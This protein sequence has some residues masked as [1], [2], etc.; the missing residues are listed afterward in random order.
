[1]RVRTVPMLFC[2]AC[3]LCAGAFADELIPEHG[4]YSE[5]YQSDW[6]KLPT[7]RELARHDPGQIEFVDVAG[8]E[9]RRS[10]IDEQEEIRIS[11]ERLRVTW[12]DPECNKY[13]HTLY[14][15]RNCERVIIEDMAVIQNHDD[16][17]AASTFF[18]ESCGRVEI[19]NCYLAGTCEKPFIRLDGCEEYFID[20]VEIAGIDFGDGY[21]CAQGIHVNNGAGLDPETGRQRYIYDENARDLTFGVIQNCYFHDYALTDPVFN[22]DAIGFH[23]PADGIVF[24]CWF[25]NWEAD[26]ALDDSH[27]RNDATYQD[28]LHRIERCVFRNCHR[29]KTNGAVGSASCSLLWCNNLYIDSSLTDYHV[30]WENWRVHETYVFTRNRGYFHVMHYREGPTYF[31]NCLLA[32]PVSLSD[33]YESMGDTPNQDIRLLRPDFFMYLMPEPV[34]WLSA[35]T[36]NTPQIDTWGQWR[37]AGFDANSTLADTDPRFVDADAGDYRLLPDSPAAGAGGPETL[38]PTDLRPAVTHDFFGNP[39]PD[40]PSCGAFE[41]AA[42]GGDQP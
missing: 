18:F 29:V 42:A 1:M 8:E 11:G 38:S 4:K 33:M 25:E 41:V 40:P 22:H 2:C 14:Y 3:A 16:W 23:A 7:G 35:R 26:S 30:G 24:N 5:S 9:V 10:F 32:S 12:Q 21:R 13:R 34:R 19:R 37:E 27:R 39:R 36:D 17:R 15:F 28:H 31:R 20:R 6:S